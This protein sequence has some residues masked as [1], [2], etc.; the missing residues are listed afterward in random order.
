MVA[1]IRNEFQQHDFIECF[2]FNLL[3]SY[4]PNVKIENKIASYRYLF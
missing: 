4:C 1:T 3:A 2:I